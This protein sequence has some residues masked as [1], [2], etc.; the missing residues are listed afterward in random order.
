MIKDRPETG[1]PSSVLAPGMIVRH[2]ARPDWGDGQV[3]SVV[4]HRVTVMFPECGKVVLDATAVPLRL[5]LAS[6]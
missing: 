3:Q 5:V 6:G 1:V 4:A 2:A